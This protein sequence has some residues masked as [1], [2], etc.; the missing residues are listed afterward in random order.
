MSRRLLLTN[1]FC[2]D[3][4][5]TAGLAVVVLQSTAR[6]SSISK[7]CSKSA[8]EA[9]RIVRN[10]CENPSFCG[11][12]T[13]IESE[14]AKIR[15]LYGGL[16]LARQLT[17]LSKIAEHDQLELSNQ[18]SAC[19]SYISRFAGVPHFIVAS[20]YASCMATFAWL[21]SSISTISL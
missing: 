4:I 2:P 15:I 14:A 5:A 6:S 7:I 21:F 11:P 17:I 16:R 10:A 13:I 3:G 19:L 9:A 1:E 18:F 20:L 12:R 8:S